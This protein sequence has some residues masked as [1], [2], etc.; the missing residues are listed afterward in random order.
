[1]PWQ[2]SMRVWMNRSKKKCVCSLTLKTK[3]KVF[4]DAEKRVRNF[5]FNLLYFKCSTSSSQWSM[6]KTNRL[7]FCVRLICNLWIKL[8]IKIEF[9]VGNVDQ[10]YHTEHSIDPKEMV[11]LA[12]EVVNYGQHSVLALHLHSLNQVFQI[13]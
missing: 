11:A 12:V 6:E 7:K 10:G 5:F 9:F 3:W 2:R 4:M 8:Q 1:M 13:N